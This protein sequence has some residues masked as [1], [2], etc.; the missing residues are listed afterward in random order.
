ML[1]NIAAC[2]T[3]LILCCKRQKLMIGN[4]WGEKR[5]FQVSSVHCKN[6]KFVVGN[7]QWTSV[8]TNDGFVLILIILLLAMSVCLARSSVVVKR[9]KWAAKAANHHDHI[10]WNL[11]NRS[12]WEED[13]VVKGSDDIDHDDHLD[14]DEDD[15]YD[16]DDGEG[17]G[18]R[19]HRLDLCWDLD[20]QNCVG[21]ILIRLI[22]KSNRAKWMKTNCEQSTIRTR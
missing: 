18:I 19:W 8:N 1:W 4:T 7:S 3:C 14:D 9:H 20:E 5:E 17:Q 13:E 21:R 15:E 11:M 6:L 10:E 2:S 16:E 22:E 12:H